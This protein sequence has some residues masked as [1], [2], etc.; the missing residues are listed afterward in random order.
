MASTDQSGVYEGVV[1]PSIAYGKCFL[2][3][4]YLSFDTSDDADELPEQ[5]APKL[6]KLFLSANISG[7]VVGPNS[8]IYSVESTVLYS[9]DGHFEFWAIDGNHS[10][11]SVQGWNWNAQ[12]TIDGKVIASFTFSPESTSSNPHNL[13]VDFPIA[14][15]TSGTVQ[16]LGPGFVSATLDDRGHL[17]ITP[18]SGSNIDAGSIGASP[19]QITKAIKDSA[20]ASSLASSAKDDAEAAQASA[21]LS[22]KASQDSANLV[23]APADAV[24]ATT[25]TTD[26]TQTRTA[27][28]TTVDAHL[29]GDSKNFLS[30][31]P[32]IALGVKTDA[33][34]LTTSSDG[35]QSAALAAFFADATLSGIRRI[36]G[37]V[38]L[39][40]TVRV[41]SGV[42]VDARR[43][44]FQQTTPKTV[45]LKVAS[46]SRISG[47]KFVGLS[48][49]YV[50]GTNTSPAS[51]AI[52]CDG[53]ATSPDTTAIEDVT[54]IGFAGAG[55]YGL[56]AKVLIDGCEFYG[57]HNLNGIIIP[58]LDSS[59][60]GLYLNGGC[61]DAIVRDSHFENT[62]IGLIGSMDSHRMTLSGLRFKN[63]PGQHGAYLQNGTG[64]LVSDI[65]GDN[66]N[67][68]L[69]KLQQGSSAME[70]AQAPSFTSVTGRSIGDCVLSINNI[71]NSLPEF[72]NTLAGS[73]KIYSATVAKITGYNSGR[74]LYLG[75][76]RGGVV[77]DAV[78]YNCGSDGLTILDCQD[79]LAENVVMNTTGNVGVRFTTATGAQNQRITLRGA[80]TNNPGNSG[81]AG[82]GYGVFVVGDSTGNDGRDITIDGLQAYATNGKMQSG[83]LVSATANQESLKVRNS[84]VRGFSSRAYQLASATRDLAEWSN[85][86]SGGSG[87]STLNFPVGRP[88]RTGSVGDGFRY[89]CNSLPTSGVFL[90]GD[91]IEI[92]PV[93]PGGVAQYVCT[94]TGGCF[95]GM[96]TASKDYTVGTYVRTAPGRVIQCIVAGTSGTVEPVVSG[97]VGSAT[98]VDG[99]VTWQYMASAPATLKATSTVA[100]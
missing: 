56:N 30:K 8:K 38:M 53:P 52:Y 95:S 62:S 31:L 66:V 98:F 11:L 7:A 20:N 18:T 47:G 45:L 15:P 99:G 68:N 91:R 69:V 72:G 22:A 63:I 23:D 85:N 5:R 14:K 4:G 71:A 77:S 84:S 60:F 33:F 96:W 24:M 61:D 90:N 89:V 82:Q 19:A 39:G 29:G 73:Y 46:G 57:V 64:L 80:R 13:G 88:V 37:T 36:A 48:T 10:S 12:L 34:R 92:S 79:L 65:G 50:A 32:T 42:T 81:Q 9:N 93:V 16:L 35:D 6:A 76:L 41:P 83:L 55:V 49:D 70:D 44:T 59:C 51:I 28:E 21:A 2:D 1:P 58:S 74:L 78:G 25:I 54:T 3:V 75:S 94:A 97:A 26:G 67:L 100:A 87:T 40:S 43:A 17:L 27:V 86:D